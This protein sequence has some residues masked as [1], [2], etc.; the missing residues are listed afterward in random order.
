MSW[1]DY[2]APSVEIPLGNDKTGKVRGLNVDDL[3][4]LITNH[5]QP[6][7]EALALYSASRKDIYSSRNLH[8]F[9]ISTASQ[10]P[11]LI[12][13][14][15]SLAADEPSLRGKKLA[16][17]VQV[18][19]LDAILKLTLDEVGGLGNLSLVLANLAKGVLSEYP[20]MAAPEPANETPS[21]NGIGG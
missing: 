12:S 20:Q 21:P 16:M 10:F 4:I 2:E 5:L 3:A 13:E 19:A 8:S 18:A 11:V 17:G 1:T 6:I 14:V 7:S 9:V 15:I